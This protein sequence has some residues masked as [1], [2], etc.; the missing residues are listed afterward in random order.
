MIVCDQNYEKTSSEKI[1][2]EENENKQASIFFYLWKQKN[3]VQ[4]RHLGNEKLAFLLS[5]AS[6]Y[7]SNR[8]TGVHLGLPGA[9]NHGLDVHR[10]VLVRRDDGMGD[11]I[12][13]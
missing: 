9:E 13:F 3:R 1:E 6:E 2:I 11:V 12:I 7:L 8:S 4:T 10:R 5:D